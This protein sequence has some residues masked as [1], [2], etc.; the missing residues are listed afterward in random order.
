[1]ENFF[2]FLLWPELCFHK[3]ACQLDPPDDVDVSFECGLGHLPC[4]EMYGA[5][6]GSCEMGVAWPRSQ[7]SECVLSLL[8]YVKQPNEWGVCVC[9]CVCVCALVPQSCLTLPLRGL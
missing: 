9:V 3:C 4:L 8:E 5:R 6:E 2:F 1:M 7:I